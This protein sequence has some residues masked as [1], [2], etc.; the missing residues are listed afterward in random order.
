MTDAVPRTTAAPAEI[1]V[2]FL[3]AL[4]R[5]D[6]DT[7]LD[8]VADDLEYIN[9]TL[10]TLH[11]KRGVRQAFG[12]LTSRPDAGFRVYFHHVATD[13]DVVL[14]DRTDEIH[15]R[16]LHARFWVYGRFEVRDG[17]ITVWRDAFDWVD[18]L[19]GTVR[20]LLGIVL[21][22]ANRPMPTS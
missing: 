20:G 14:T 13:G 4:A 10:P 8:L 5:D 15:F 9:V 22:G 2:E 12:T 19:I 21:Q 16:R 7:A 6:L 17:K 3:N 1:V 11:G 18:I